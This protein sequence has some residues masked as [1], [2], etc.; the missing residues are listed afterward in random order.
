MAKRELRKERA[1]KESLSMRDVSYNKNY[2]PKTGSSKVT[3]PPSVPDDNDSKEES[4][5]SRITPPTYTKEESEARSVLYDT[6][7]FDEESRRKELLRGASAQIRSMEDVYSQKEANERALGQKDLAR[8][9]TISAMTGMMGAPEAATR[10]GN[11][12]RRTEDRVRIVND[13]KQLALSA[14]YKD[15]DS[16]LAREKESHLQTQRDNAKRVLDEIAVSARNALSGFAAQGLSWDQLEKSDPDTVQNLIRQSGQDAFTLRQLYNEALPPD[17]KPQTIF[18]GFKGNNF[19]MIRRNA[20]GTI[21]NETYDATE[22][23]IPDTF[24]DPSSITLGDTVYWYDKENPVDENGNPKLIKLGLKA[25]KGDSSNDDDEDSDSPQEDLLSFDDWKKSEDAQKI[26][27]EQMALE[28]KESGTSSYTDA[29]ADELLRSVYDES[30]KNHKRSS[31]KKG[32]N[33]TATTIPSNIKSDLIADIQRGATINELY[34]AYGDVSTSYVS[35]LYNSLKPKKSTDSG[36]SVDDLSNEEF[37]QILKR[38]K[39]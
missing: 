39:Q 4:Y 9:N 25:G 36:S 19:V 30:V 15:I 6:E 21:T 37:I 23:G 31:A 12:D 34:S 10:A 26:L 28:V 35:S 1:Q 29:E 38:Q 16:N 32:S 24:T 17:K 18:E 2:K 7:D 14:I 11:A 3:P 8:S 20:D 22:L 27:R 5:Y 13:Q 33:Y